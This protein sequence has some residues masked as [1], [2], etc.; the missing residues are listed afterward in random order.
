MNFSLNNLT[1][2]K[3]SI[4]ASFSIAVI[5][6][7][8]V[9]TPYSHCMSLTELH[10]PSLSFVC[11]HSSCD[12]VLLFCL[13]QTPTL[14]QTSGRGSQHCWGIIHL[15]MVSLLHTLTNDPNR[16]T[17]SVPLAFIGAYCVYFILSPLCL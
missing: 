17:E 5:G 6:I 15:N 1:S 12:A 13:F 14:T 16:G 4:M 9:L 2:F 11:D 10:S 3:I 8:V 7:F